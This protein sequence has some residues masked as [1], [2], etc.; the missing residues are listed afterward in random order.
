MKTL[1]IVYNSS[2][3]RTCQMTEAAAKGAASEPGVN[4]RLLPAAAALRWQRWHERG[5]AARIAT[6]WRLRAVAEPLIVW[7]HA[8]TPEAILA[9][10]VIAANDL[11]Q[12]HALG[13]TLAARLATGVF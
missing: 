4:V 6:G 12:C 5:P 8:Q 11:D 13:A 9:P 10:K 1:L 2:T 7:T 3:V